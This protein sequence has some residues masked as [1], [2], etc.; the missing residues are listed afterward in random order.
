M[1]DPSPSAEAPLLRP[2]SRRTLLLAGLGAAAV[3]AL[4]VFER[5]PAAAASAGTVLPLVA[6][7]PA[8]APNRMLFAPN[9]QVLA[10]Y[11]M[12][13]APMANDIVDDD[14][15][16]FGFMGGGWW[17]TPSEP[18]NARVQEHVATLSWF[19]ANERSWNPYYLDSALL[20]RLDAAIGHYLRIQHPNG[21]FP[22]YTTTEFS[23][24]ATAFGMVA[25]SEALANLRA[26]NALP[27]RQVELEAALRRASVWFMDLTNGHWKIPLP[28]VNQTVGGLAGIARAARVLDDAQLAADLSDRIDFIAE[29]GQAP[30]GFFHEPFGFDFGYN[31]F[32]MLPDLADLH[33]ITGNPVVLD[34]A[35]KWTD[36]A[37]HAVVREP[38][39]SGYIAHSAACSR[40]ADWNF[41]TNFTDDAERGALSA[42]LA[43]EA[44][45]LA[46]FLTTLEEKLASRGAW[47]ATP[48]PV[49][50]RAKQGTSPRLWMHVIERPDV[51]SDADRA[52]SEASLPYIMSERFTER[53]VGTLAQDYV[54][55]R[56]PA[57]YLSS[58]FG[59][60]SQP[61]NR[62]GPGLLW[63]PQMGT[64]LAATNT[65]VGAASWGFVDGAGTDST[66][67]DMTVVYRHGNSGSGAVIVPDA[68]DAETGVITFDA[69]SSASGT[70]ALTT[71]RDTGLT[72]YADAAATGSFRLPLVLRATDEVTY[73]N[74]A[75]ATFN[76]TSAAQATWVRVQRNGVRM[77][78]SW[79]AESAVTLSS[80]PM[81][82][83]GGTRRVHQLSIPVGA[84]AL[85]EIEFAAPWSSN[86]TYT[87]GDRVN[88][89]GSFWVAQWWT[90][91]LRPG[92]PTGPWSQLGCELATPDGPVRTWTA[93]WIYK[94]DE[95]VLYHGV[96]Y[97]ARWWSR[98]QAPDGSGGAWQRVGEI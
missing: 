91:D 29:H 1:T 98:N 27:E 47:A 55:A 32:V 22:E 74:G 8:G 28:F 34:M 70:R 9:E 61:M 51:P 37:R 36:F 93:S 12:I 24:A 21:A 39:V 35:Q 66:L 75:T 30:A 60:R 87:T 49:V 89:E 25:L 23:R 16:R 96:I 41:L 54:F 26:T 67:S 68:L 13:V 4:G 44:P 31:F 53:R 45:E 92:D 84:S 63:H 5:S 20:G 97:R 52:A 18:F 90:R 33:V 85:I 88:F 46:A 3:T 40:T 64:V 73:S 94:G 43:P 10:A 80:T 79:G 56:R 78:I 57:Y 2:L 82:L 62:M 69:T 11:L 15:D 14:P 83:L 77:Q 38:D 50:A 58:F 6:P 42:A 71:L 72:L 7:L 81:T 19:Y 17:R 76:A 65:S 95:K 59:T 48:D 86:T